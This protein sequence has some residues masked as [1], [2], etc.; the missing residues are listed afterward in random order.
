MRN[1]IP[2]AL[3]LSLAAGAAG[4]KKTHYSADCSR[5]VSLAAPWDTMKLPLGDNTRVC[6]SN[7][8]KTDIEALDGDRAA[9]ETRYEQVM[10]A[11]GYTKD[12]CSSTSCSYL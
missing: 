5:A 10:T 1:L 12:R 7:D 3:A 9:W 8:L 4:C 2:F 6:S 11:G